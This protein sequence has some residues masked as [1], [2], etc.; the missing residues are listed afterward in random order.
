MTNIKINNKSICL[1]D[2]RI[3]NKEIRSIMGDP[4][5]VENKKKNERVKPFPFNKGNI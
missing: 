4:Y 3:V 2:Q 5:L 1:P